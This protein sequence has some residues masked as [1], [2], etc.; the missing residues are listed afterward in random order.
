MQIGRNIEHHQQCIEKT[1]FGIA[2]RA[3]TALMSLVERLD[4]TQ[5]RPL[6]ERRNRSAPALI[7]ATSLY[8]R[9]FPDTATAAPRVRHKSPITRNKNGEANERRAFNDA[10]HLP[11]LSRKAG[12]KSRRPCTAT[13]R[14]AL[15]NT[16]HREEDTSY[17]SKQQSKGGH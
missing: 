5:R 16:H 11:T 1:L 6:S 17:G 8:M 12:A 15:H 14:L 4:R 7:T 9:R 2:S 10:D 13:D 3:D